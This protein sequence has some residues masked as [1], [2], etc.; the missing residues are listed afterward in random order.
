MKDGAMREWA[1]GVVKTAKRRNKV[2]N[3]P[4]KIDS[5]A[6]PDMID[7][8]QAPGECLLACLCAIY[9]VSYREV[10]SILAENKVVWADAS[11]DVKQQ[12]L[13]ALFSLPRDWGIRLVRD[14]YIAIAHFH[15]GDH[16]VIEFYPGTVWCPTT[17]WFISR[18]A[19][20]DAVKAEHGGL[21]GVDWYQPWTVKETQ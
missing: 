19:Y 4:G 1:A 12:W 15:T 3:V 18:H 2:L 9:E 11:G 20:C 8:L 5:A 6:M 16:A 13:A 10:R 7:T 17:G 14:S 21:L